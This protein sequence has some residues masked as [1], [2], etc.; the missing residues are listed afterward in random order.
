MQIREITCCQSGC[1]YSP[2]PMEEGFYLRARRTHEFWT[3]PAG[4]RQHFAGESDHEREM[5]LLKEGHAREVRLLEGDAAHWRSM[6]L[7]CP[8][9]TCREFEYANRDGVYQHMVRVHGM[10]RLADVRTEVA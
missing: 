1:G 3:C 5:R 8:W 4:H 2:F 10:P 7:M 9:P 6:A